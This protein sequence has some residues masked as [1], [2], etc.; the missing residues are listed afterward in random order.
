M[1]AWDCLR[2]PSIGRRQVIRPSRSH[3]LPLL[4]ERLDDPSDLVRLQAAHFLSLLNDVRAEE[5]IATVRRRSERDR[6]QRAPI[7]NPS[8]IWFVG[9]FDDRGAGFE[10]IH[11]PEATAIDLSAHYEDDSRQLVWQKIKRE[12]MFGLSQAAREHR[13]AFCIRL[14]EADKSPRP[15]GNA[16]AR[17]GRR[18]PHLE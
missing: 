8:E 15:A 5:K 7:D 3:C 6:L 14:L 2:S 10:T 4:F 18:Y 9:P 13:W 12:R 16:T 11:T 17:V 1:A